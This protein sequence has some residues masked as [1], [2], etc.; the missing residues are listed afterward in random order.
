M[1]TVESKFSEE[2]YFR[3]DPNLR[4]E[5]VAKLVPRPVDQDTYDGHFDEDDVSFVQ[6]VK[7]LPT[8]KNLK[9]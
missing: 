2:F 1:F 8:A 9:Y 6:K 7:A 5:E 3:D 4:P